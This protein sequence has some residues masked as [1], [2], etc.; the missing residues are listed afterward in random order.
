MEAC[1]GSLA[2]YRVELLI[3]ALFEGAN[4]RGRLRLERGPV[5][6]QFEIMDGMLVAESSN[7]P[8]EHLAQ[9]LANLKVLDAGRAA[10]AYEAAEA[11]K[12]TYGAFLVERGFLERDR[13]REVLEHKARESFFDCYGWQSGSFEFTP[14]EPSLSPQAVRLSLQ[15]PSL[16]RDGLARRR[17]WRAFQAQFPNP[18]QHFELVRVPRDLP[19][20]ELAML[21]LAARGATLED[22]LKASPDG[23]MAAARRLQSLQRRDY[24]LAVPLSQP[25]DAEEPSFSDTMRLAQ[26][27][28]FEGK[29]EEAAA[30]TSQVLERGPVEEAQR[31]Y[32]EAEQLLTGSASQA[33]AT[34]AAAM[35]LAPSPTEVP[36]GVTADDL[37]L[38]SKLRQARDPAL[39]LR[40]AAMGELAAYRSVKRLMEAG[41][42]DVE[43]GEPAGEPH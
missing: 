1:K 33:L 20:E 9:L 40:S 6:R 41:L 23:A 34:L 39:A 29:T 10:A 32:G 14:G 7:Q 13:L 5:R 38:L 37:Y 12:V 11:L 42:L 26:S 8:G 27:L 28:L 15:L 31:L 4:V 17:E 25:V 19:A 36:Q 24:L 30:L 18:Q 22:L 43:P 16:H 21:E 3:P 2:H 35:R